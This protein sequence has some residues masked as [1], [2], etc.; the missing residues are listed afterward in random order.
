MSLLFFKPPYLTRF[1]E[2]V[3]FHRDRSLPAAWRRCQGI[4]DFYDQLKKR[5]VIR[6]AIVYAALAWGVLQVVDLL[7]EA[8]FLSESL[9]RVIIIATLVGFP[10]TLIFSWFFEA[11]WRQR[12]GLS[13]IG[14]VVVILAIALGVFLFA[15]QQYFMSFTRP[16]LAV[17]LIEATDARTDSEV[18]GPYLAGR[19][20]TTLAARP[21]LVVTEMTS[22]LR[23]ELT[24]WGITRKARSL[25]ADFI[26]TGTLNQDKDILRV[27]LQLYDNEGELVWSAGFEDRLI[28]LGELESRILEELW[29]KLPLPVDGLAKSLGPITDCEYPPSAEAIRTLILADSGK[30]Q[31]DAA[32][33]E[34]NGLIENYQDNGLLHLV[35]ARAFFGKLIDAAPP[36]KP[37]INNLALQDLRQLSE[38][39]PGYTQAALL[40]LHQNPVKLE[41]PKQIELQ[42]LAFPNDA[43]LMRAFAEAWLRTGDTKKAVAAAK[44][45]WR[46]DPLGTDTLCAVL[47]LIRISGNDDTADEIRLHALEFHPA[48]A[49]DCDSQASLQ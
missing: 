25:A 11:P 19:I 29:M 41:E 35:R 34:L 24:S 43:F 5:R 23:P 39:C 46:L 32:V 6:T 31:P 33:E 47:D 18:L 26:L 7:A 28:D 14:D 2:C 49:L 3:N 4:R 17:T 9:V 20:R 13:V 15:W 38:R 44:E 27:N 1:D 8:A 21:E 37:V 48:K 16:T 42:L 30:L 40:S 45:V 36:R 12:K 10:F 22:S